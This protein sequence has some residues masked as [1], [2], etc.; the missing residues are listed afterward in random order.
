MNEGAVKQAMLAEFGAI[1]GYEDRGKDT[2]VCFQCHTNDRP[3]KKDVLAPLYIRGRG[4]PR[5]IKG[6]LPTYDILHRIFRETVAPRA[7]NVDEIHAF[8][9]DIMMAT[10]HHRDSGLPMDVMDVIW[11]EMVCAT[12]QRRVP[13]FAPYIM[14]LIISKCPVIAR[15]LP[16]LR[17]ATH[18]HKNLLIKTHLKPRNADGQIVDEDGNPVVEESGDADDAQQDADFV[19]SRRKPA[20]PSWGKRFEANSRRYSASKWTIRNACT[21]PMSMPRSHVLVRRK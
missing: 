2:P 19:V 6:L 10:Y 17:L 9:V 16:S 13:P 14:A 3:M 18:R 21:R 5:K 12:F 1:L 8:M 15:D 11:N 7:G 20:Q 4:I